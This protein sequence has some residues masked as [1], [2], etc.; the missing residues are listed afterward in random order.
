MRVGIVGLQHEANTFLPT[1]T[2]IAEFEQG[3][4]VIGDQVRNRY[5]DAH[6]EVGG[7]FEGLAEAGIEAVP[8]FLAWAVPAG[9]VTDEALEELLERMFAALAEAGPLDGILAAPHGAGVSKSQPDMDGYWLGLLRERVGPKVPIVAT[10]DLHA[11]LS[12]RMVAACDAMVAY[13]TNPHLDQR[14]RGVEAARLGARHLRGEI[15]L[16]QAASYPPVVINI[17]RQFTA[18][19][20]CRELYAELERVRREPGVLSAS[21]LLGFPYADVPEMGASSV[22]VTDDNPRLAEELAERLAGYLIA[23]RR[24]FVGQLVD[25]ETA[26]EQAQSAPGPVCLLDMG[27]NVGGG[28]PGDGTV[29]LAALWGARSRGIARSLVAIYDPQSVNQAVAAGV[30]ATLTFEI[31]GKTDQ[32]H[33][34]P[35]VAAARVV[36]LHDGKFRESEPRHGGQT[37]FD[38]GTSAVLE[39]DAGPTVLVTSRRMAPFSLNQIISCGLDPGA[40]QVIVAKGVHAPVAAY[41]PVCLTMIRVNTTGVTCADLGQLQYR[42]RRRPLFPF[43]DIAGR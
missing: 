19:S 33:G 41:A 20:P 26:L 17:E 21:V 43:E 23:E 36:S 5:G 6:H 27:D 10:L 24:Q 2:G 7:F 11:N 30:G 8:I 40:F 28:S 18:A 3:G 4:L 12:P 15:R 39:L 22:V 31:G 14:Q 25:V 9:V 34:Q 37:Q 29:L 13:R 42:N 32:R 35:V 1:P 38:M 16:S